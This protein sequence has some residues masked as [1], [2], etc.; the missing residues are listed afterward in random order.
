LSDDLGDHATGGSWLGQSFSMAQE[1]DDP[2]FVAYLF[3]RMAKRA[4]VARTRTGS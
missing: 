2:D 3:A 4:A 1:A